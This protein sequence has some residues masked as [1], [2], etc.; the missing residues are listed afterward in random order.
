MRAL[1]RSCFRACV[2]VR[3]RAWSS[4][5]EISLLLSGT[6]GGMELDAFEAKNARVSV[7]KEMGVLLFLSTSPPSGMTQIDYD[8]MLCSGWGIHVTCKVPGGT[9]GTRVKDFVHE[10]CY[11]VSTRCVSYI[12]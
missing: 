1:V 8:V 4:M 6:Y 9:K 10:F 2:C 7:L 12:S 3:A 11:L 5:N